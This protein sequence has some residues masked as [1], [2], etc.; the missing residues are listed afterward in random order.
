MNVNKQQ[1]EQIRD[2]RRAA[3][4]KTIE[5]KDIES[6]AAVFLN[7]QTNNDSSLLKDVLKNQLKK[8]SRRE[9]Q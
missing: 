8:K 2:I 9:K 6:E 3:I 5:K 7:K 1:V 4:N